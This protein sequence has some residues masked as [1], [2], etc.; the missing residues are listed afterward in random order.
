[1]IKRLGQTF[2][3]ICLYFFCMLINKVLMLNPSDILTIFTHERKHLSCYSYST[4]YYKLLPFP[5][6]TPP[7]THKLLLRPQFSVPGPHTP[8]FF[9]YALKPLPGPS[10]PTPSRGKVQER[11][12]IAGRDPGHVRVFPPAPWAQESHQAIRPA[13]SAQMH[14]AKS[15]ACGGERKEES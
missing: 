9:P 4:Q 5:L 1:M 3:N 15:G 12:K 11:K 7:D 2:L 8:G 14:V 6:F 10:Q 13:I